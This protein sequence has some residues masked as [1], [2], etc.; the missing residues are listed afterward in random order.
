VGSRRDC[1]RTGVGLR[2]TVAEKNFE[3]RMNANGREVK[4]G[5]K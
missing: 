5:E 2:G 3:P 4:R 1:C